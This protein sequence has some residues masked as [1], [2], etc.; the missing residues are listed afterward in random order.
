MSAIILSFVMAALEAAIQPIRRT[1][2][3]RHGWMAGSKPGHDEEVEWLA[4]G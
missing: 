3:G 2:G 1:A 4:A